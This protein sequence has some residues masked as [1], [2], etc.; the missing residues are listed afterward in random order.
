MDKI[1]TTYT[2]AEVKSLVADAHF[3]AIQQAYKEVGEWLEELCTEPHSAGFH[4][5][6]KDCTECFVFL[7]S[8]RMPEE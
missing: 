7:K 2:D 4:R 1:T 5:V 6:R 3:K 8:G